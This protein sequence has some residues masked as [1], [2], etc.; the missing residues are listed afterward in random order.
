MNNLHDVTERQTILIVD[1]TPDNIALLSAL[2]KGRYKIKVATHGARALKIAATVPS[3]DL[4]LLDIVMPGMDGY[5]VCRRLK[6]DP[7]TTHIPVIFL[8]AKPEVEAEEKGLK[9]GAVDYI[10]KPISPSILLARVETHI[11]LKNTRQFLQN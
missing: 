11:T 7:H 3:P 9:L 2:L 1:D 8:T 4:I 6:D 5:E 10:T